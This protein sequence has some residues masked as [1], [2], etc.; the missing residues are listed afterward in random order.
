MTTS[1]LQT[2]L[3]LFSFAACGALAFFYVQASKTKTLF[4]AL[5]KE[6][7]QLR[8]E[9]KRL[10][11]LEK[12]TRNKHTENT[13]SLI[14]LKKD[15]HAQKSKNH[16]LGE[17][18]RKLREQQK[19]RIKDLESQL[20]TKPAFENM[21]SISATLVKEPTPIV[22]AQIIPKQPQNDEKIN[23]LQQHIN[24]LD[25]RLKRGHASFQELEQELDR[26]RTKYSDMRGENSTLHKRLEDMRKIQIVSK[27]KLQV[28]E[29]K[30]RYFGKAYYETLSELAAL[31]GEVLPPRPKEFSAA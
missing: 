16:D 11:E 12:N 8:D 24:D 7:M 15:L 23:V 17:E 21:P 2:I 9:Q 13:Q 22:V 4:A 19:T 30:L 25:E 29:D 5:H 18:L 1:L 10:T 26:L 14:E 31:K 3:G 6:H 27:S 20:H 28:T